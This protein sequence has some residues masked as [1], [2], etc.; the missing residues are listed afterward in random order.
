[1]L[2][3]S[4]GR[5][6]I[7]GLDT[8]TLK[9]NALRAHLNAVP[10]DPYFLGGSIRLNL[11]PYSTA[12]DPDL[13]VALQCVKL[14]DTVQAK[15]GLDAELT[16]DVLSHGQRQLF[17]LARAILR[18]GKIVVLDEATSRFVSPSLSPFSPKHLRAGLC[19]CICGNSPVLIG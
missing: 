13:T 5:I 19:Y 12:S 8:S 18:P 2:E 7:D 1:M 6:T 16:P 15:G 17:C 10:Q 3:L 14:W 4:A 11:D 9:R